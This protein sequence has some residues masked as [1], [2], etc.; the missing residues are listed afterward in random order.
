MPSSVLIGHTSGVL[1]SGSL[2][3]SISP[4]LPSSGSHAKASD[5]T[6]HQNEAAATGTALS[7]LQQFVDEGPTSPML[8]KQK[9]AGSAKTLFGPDETGQ[10]RLTGGPDGAQSAPDQSL[11]RTSPRALVVVSGGQNVGSEQ[12]EQQMKDKGILGSRILFASRGVHSPSSV[13]AVSSTIPA[14]NRK[15]VKRAEVKIDNLLVSSSWNALRNRH[16]TSYGEL[17][18][19]DDK[20]D[21]HFIDYSNLLKSGKQRVIMN[22]PGFME[23]VISYRNKRELKRE[24]NDKFQSNHEWMVQNITLSKIRR[25]RKIL[26]SIIVELDMEVS[27]AALAY[28]Y[29]ERLI[30]KNAVSKQNRKL[31]L[32]IVLILAYKYNECEVGVDEDEG[33][34]E[35]SVDKDKSALVPLF[36]ALEKHAGVRKKELLQH[37]FQVLVGLDMGLNVTPKQIEAVYRSFVADCETLSEQQQ[38]RLLRRNK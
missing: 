22:L 21:P 17:L 37:E 20:Y 9:L 4:D 15:R 10:P 18:E 31:V 28:I 25:M 36:A 29:L 3:L 27:T 35:R 13:F 2:E 14:K 19:V 24:L 26:V 7:L 30:I 12:W 8:L 23:S 38:Q 33:G 6:A 32:G 11:P 1:A 16:G 34:K 5:G